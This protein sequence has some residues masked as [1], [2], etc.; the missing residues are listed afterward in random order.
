MARKFVEQGYVEYDAPYKLRE[1]VTFYERGNRK[2]LSV[3]RKVRK[4]MRTRYAKKKLVDGRYWEP[5]W[6]NRG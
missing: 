2:K 5:L 6:L 4:E 1:A 3:W